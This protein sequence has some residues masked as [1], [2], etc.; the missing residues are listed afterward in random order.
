MREERIK[1][2]FL[3]A[4]PGFLASFQL[5]DPPSSPP[6]MP[7]EIEDPSHSPIAPASP[8]GL[9]TASHH[10][11]QAASQPSFSPKTF[12]KESSDNPDY[13]PRLRSSS[14]PGGPETAQVAEELETMSHHSLQAASQPSFTPKPLADEGLDLPH[15]LPNLPPSSPTGEAPEGDTKQHS[16]R[17]REE[18]IRNTFLAAIPDFLASF[19]SSTSP[20]SSLETHESSSQAYNME[21][22]DYGVPDLEDNTNTEMSM[23]E[24]GTATPTQVMWKDT[25]PDDSMH[26]SED[27]QIDPMHFHATSAKGEVDLSVGS[28]LRFKRSNPVLLKQL[29]LNQLREHRS[30]E[31]EVKKE[32]AEDFPSSPAATESVE[33]IIDRLSNHSIRSGDQ[34][35]AKQYPTRTQGLRDDSM[36]PGLSRL[37]YNTSPGLD[38]ANSGI[39]N[40]V[41]MVKFPEKLFKTNWDSDV[42]YPV[43]IHPRTSGL[44]QILIICSAGQPWVPTAPQLHGAVLHVSFPS[45]HWPVMDE[46]HVF[47]VNKAGTE[48][49][50]VGKYRTPRDGFWENEPIK[51]DVLDKDAIARLPETVNKSLTDRLYIY[52]ARG[53]VYF[54]D[55]VKALAAHFCPELYNRETGNM[56]PN[57]KKEELMTKLK[58]LEKHDVTEALEN[59]SEWVQFLD[60]RNLRLMR[61]RIIVTCHWDCGSSGSLLRLS[62]GTRCFMKSL[63]HCAMMINED[64]VLMRRKVGCAGD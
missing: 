15:Y 56:K 11:L 33:G 46:L 18:K 42:A 36:P 59:V 63:L 2:N 64:M 28:P 50:Y 16:V 6:K 53:Q 22:S 43:I 24:S 35:L 58:A 19:N 17:E 57:Q 32:T 3:A 23:R 12:A 13:L 8:P 9:E 60:R 14:P 47:I 31:E 26:T 27:V 41:D 44:P 48:F 49:G 37:G 25:N 21:T 5:P 39:P 30:E 4:L 45:T 1:N 20:L 61:C 54:V 29:A 7:S 10:S 55:Y 40:F 38:P 51:P 34:P 62:G 52:G